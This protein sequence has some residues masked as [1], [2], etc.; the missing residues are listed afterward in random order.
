M[1]NNDFYKVYKEKTT[2]KTGY[3]SFRV[4]NYFN[5]RYLWIIWGNTRVMRPSQRIT[6]LNL[7]IP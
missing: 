3:I 2:K 5:I 7:I 4:I 1:S 6:R